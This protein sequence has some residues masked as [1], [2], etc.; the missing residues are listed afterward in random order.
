MYSLLIDIEA[1]CWD[2]FRKN[3]PQEIIEFACVVLDDFGDR[4]GVYD[5]L[6]R[7][8][9]NPRLSYYC[10]N[11]TGIDQTKINSASTFDTI[12]EDWLD[13]L[14]EINPIMQFHMYSWGDFDYRILQDEVKKRGQ[15][16]FFIQQFTDLK[17]QYNR[18]YGEENREISLRS[19]LKREGIDWE[20]DKH[21]AL[22]DTINMEKLYLTYLGEWQH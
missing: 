6:V 17:D 20:G 8:T 7:P 21:R 10:K 9:D 14:D 19:A 5:T 13:F 11:L 2:D 4:K 16:L 15:D 1:T 12:Y 3:E 18:L 22:S